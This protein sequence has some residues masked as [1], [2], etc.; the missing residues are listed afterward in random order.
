MS[1]VPALQ[2][3]TKPVDAFTVATAVRLLLQLPPTVPLLVEVVVCPIQ[4]DDTL[5]T[6]P[7]LQLTAAAV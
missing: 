2:A 6:V 3:V 7:A 5:L 4:S 1:V